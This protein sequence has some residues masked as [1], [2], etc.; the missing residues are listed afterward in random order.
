MAREFLAEKK[1]GGVKDRV[2]LGQNIGGCFMLEIDPKTN[3]E[4]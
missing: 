2:F 1:K 4:V 3:E